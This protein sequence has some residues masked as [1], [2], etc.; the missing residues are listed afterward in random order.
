MRLMTRTVV[1]AA[2]SALA[3]VSSA[4]AAEH[5]W[6]PA[7]A[8]KLPLW[9][10][11]NLLGK[12][13][14]NWRNGPFLEE[15]F[16]LISELGFNFVRLPM[17]YRTWIRGGDWRSFDEAVLKEIDQAVE[18]GG[19]YGIHVSINFHRAPG[20]TVASPKEKTDLWADPETQEVCALHWATF[21]RRYKGT[22]NER[23]SF[24]LFNEP[25]NVDGATY[26]RVAKGIVE[27]IRKEDPARLI[28]ADGLSWGKA[29]CQELY[30]L[31]IAQATRGYTPSYISHYKAE[32]AGSWDG[33]PVP[34]WPRTKAIGW[35]AGDGKKELQKPL[36]VDGPFPKSADLRL[37]VGVVSGRAHLIVEADGEPV[38]DK[39]LVPGEG[40]GEW[41]KSVFKPEWNIYQNVY[42]RDY[43]A[44]IPAGTLRAV[45]RVQEGDWMTL[46]E[47]GI[48]P[49]GRDTEAALTLITDYGKTPVPIRYDAANTA[50]PFSTPER[51]DRAWLWKDGIEPWLA[52]QKAGVGVMVGEFGAYKH[53]PHDAVL[54]WL[55]DSLANWK[56][57][58]WGW[59]MWNFRGTFGILDSDRAD[60]EY[61]DFRG[62]KLDRKMLDLLLKYR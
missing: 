12:F 38:F 41:K 40:E 5:T 23:L 54:R 56:K 42:D 18:W 49:E 7:S 31:C 19:R 13:H 9:R 29:P 60:V 27:A 48:R 51:E 3:A 14:L 58:G 28:I 26:Y 53:T 55:E 61:E 15:D 30:P 1:C 39:L 36:V 8:E 52:A 59:A 37:R 21:A 4:S 47:I 6:L 24:N 45:V 20:Y 50:E 32:W 10:G 44:R 2:A 16:R 33:V 62:H 11:F 46:S 17:D 25:S 22:P 35:L 43:T 34:G 57:A